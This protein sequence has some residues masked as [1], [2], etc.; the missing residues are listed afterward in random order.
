MGDVGRVQVVELALQFGQILA[1]HQ[2]FHQLVVAAFLAVGQLLDQSL[3]VQQV[4]HLS[5]AILQ[6]FLRL[7]RFSFAHDGALPVPQRQDGAPRVI[8]LSRC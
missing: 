8:N 3:P 5:Q 1:V 2:I 7:F 6:A 4:D